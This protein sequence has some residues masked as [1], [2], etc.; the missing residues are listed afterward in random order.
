MFQNINHNLLSVR[1][2]DHKEIWVFVDS[3]N[4]SIRGALSFVKTRTWRL[5]TSILDA[6][7][8]PYVF[9][10]CEN[11]ITIRLSL[12]IKNNWLIIFLLNLEKQLNHSTN[13]LFQQWTFLFYPVIIWSAHMNTRP[14]GYVAFSVIG[15]CQ[16]PRQR[17]DMSLYSYI[18]QSNG[19]KEGVDIMILSIMRK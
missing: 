4:K 12:L 9:K 16:M 1:K 14:S 8:V 10:L 18:M 5:S 13:Y 11:A 2:S 3:Y 6:H 15:H 7:I 19:R 17:N